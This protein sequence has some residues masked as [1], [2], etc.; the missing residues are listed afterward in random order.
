MRACARAWRDG[1]VPCA[2]GV[3]APGHAKRD[4]RDRS[5]TAACAPPPGHLPGC[6]LSRLAS[7]RWIFN[8]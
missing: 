1:A 7:A 2:G 6:Q 3:C 8:P 4:D 5:V